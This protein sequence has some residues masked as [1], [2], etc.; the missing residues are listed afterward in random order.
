M[1]ASLRPLAASVLLTPPGAAV[2]PAL[3]S[4]GSFTLPILGR[5]NWAEAESEVAD[6]ASKA[7]IKCFIITQTGLK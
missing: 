1:R 2:V 7:N 6:R 4:A 3:P 5:V